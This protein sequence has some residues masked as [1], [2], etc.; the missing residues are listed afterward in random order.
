M[1][2]NTNWQ[3]ELEIVAGILDSLPLEKS[4]KWGADVYSFEGRN[5]VSYGGFKH[6]FAIWFF[7]GVFLSDPLQVLV[8]AQEGKTKALRQWRF[9]DIT[10]I[11]ESIIKDY[12]LEAIDVEKKGLRIKPE[13][14]VVPDIPPFLEKVLK[15]NPSLKDQF[16][17]LSP[18]KR[19]EYINYLNEAKQESTRISRLEKIKPLILQGVGLNDKYKSKN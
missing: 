9:Q 19:K 3:K 11:N 7:N 15:S 12:I 13:A 2:K 8:S 4:T 1:Q 16:D 17:K 10:E 5:V 18:G 6:Y 14:V